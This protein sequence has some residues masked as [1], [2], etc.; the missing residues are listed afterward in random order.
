MAYDTKRG[1]PWRIDVNP[2]TVETLDPS[3]GARLAAFALPQP[4]PGDSYLGI[5]YDPT[6]DLLYVSFCPA[7]ACTEVHTVDPAN[8]ADAGLLFQESSFNLFGLAFDPSSD[9]LWAGDAT[10]VRHLTLTG[11]VIR[12]STGLSLETSSMG[13]NSYLDK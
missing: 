2:S 5:A 11:E 13:S 12:R 1:V 9:T 3:T 10:V 6:R 8:G 4:Q 7:V